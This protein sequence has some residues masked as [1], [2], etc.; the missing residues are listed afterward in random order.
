M[1]MNHFEDVLF[2][3]ED[4]LNSRKIKENLSSF[5]NFDINAFT[6]AQDN[7]E[8]VYDTFV[9]VNERAWYYIL[10]GDSVQTLPPYEGIPLPP[11][12]TRS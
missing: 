10:W 7:N 5:E 6:L 12:R 8:E 4:V 1:D 3:L 9:D 11:Q 2:A